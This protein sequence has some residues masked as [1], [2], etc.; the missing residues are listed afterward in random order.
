ME[1]QKIRFA[2]QQKMT[3]ISAS[4]PSQGCRMRQFGPLLLAQ[5]L[6]FAWKMLDSPLKNFR[7]LVVRLLFLRIAYTIPQRDKQTEC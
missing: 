6:M 3:K 1:R 7:E 2:T 5:H 4:H